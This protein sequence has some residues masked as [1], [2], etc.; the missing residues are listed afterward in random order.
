MQTHPEGRPCEDTGGDSHLQPRRGTQEKAGL[1]RPR[2]LAT[3]T[4]GKL[5]LLYKGP[6]VFYFVIMPLADKYKGRK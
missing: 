2:N 4:G 1:Q 3:G 5:I 6:S